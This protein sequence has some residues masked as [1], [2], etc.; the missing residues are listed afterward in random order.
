MFDE[1]EVEKAEELAKKYNID[2]DALRIEQL[3]L[4]KELVIKDKIDFS[5]ADR[6]GAVENIF[7]NN[8]LLSCFIIC[9]K[10][11]EILDRAY[12]FEK[13][14]FPY[15]SGFRSYRE[16][17]PMIIAFEKLKEKPD[18]VFVSGNG[19]THP[20]LGLASHFSLSIEGI[21]TIGVANNIMECKVKGE[22]VLKKGKKVGK[23]LLTK[24]GSNPM[25]ISPGNNITLESSYD[26]CKKM[27]NLPHK[28]PEPL[29]LARKY[30]KEVQREIGGK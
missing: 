17:V 26:L 29:H 3:K 6:F 15:I 30:A 11:Y 7:F 28:K 8:K 21:P 2:L 25:Y 19:I 14:K 13:V 16:I 1:E 4:A 20:R 24:T 10:D 22:D 5:L 27:I 9:N 18:I 23:I 12:A